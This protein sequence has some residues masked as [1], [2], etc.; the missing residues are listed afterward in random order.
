MFPS[1]TIGVDVISFVRASI[2]ETWPTS[3]FAT[4][5][6]PSPK[7]SVCA[8]PTGIKMRFCNSPVFGI[9]PIDVARI[10]VSLR[11]PDRAR[12][13]DNVA[14]L[15]R[16]EGLRHRQRIPIGDHR[17]IQRGIDPHE[18]R[19]GAVGDPHRTLADRKPARDED[20]GAEKRDDLP[21]SRIDSG[22]LAG[23]G[24]APERARAEPS[25]R[26]RPGPPPGQS[27]CRCGPRAGRR[28]RAARTTVRAGPAS[29]LL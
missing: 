16:Q 29:H 20:A 24:E 21:R 11:N 19:R 4:Q 3:A 15:P 10:R 17:R 7:A 14:R 8:P 13:Q 23:D 22:Q 18:R 9:E 12:A 2:L 1:P 27:P 5:S 26:P 28:S 6:A 25:R